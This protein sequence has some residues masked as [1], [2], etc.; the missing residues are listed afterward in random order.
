[1]PRSTGLL[2]DPANH[3]RIWFES[4]GLH[5]IANHNGRIAAI[6]GYMRDHLLQDYQLPADALLD[7]PDGL[8][9]FEWSFEEGPPALSSGAQA[10]FMLAL[11][12]ARPYKG[13]DDLLDALAELRH[14]RIPLPHA[15]L[16]AVTDQPCPTSYQRHLSFSIKSLGLDATLLT[17]FDPAIRTLLA[18]PALRTVVIPS[19]AEPFGRVPLEA[20]AAGA[21]PV[22]AT[23]AGGLAEQVIDGVTGLTASPADPVSLARAIDRALSLTDDERDRMRCAGRY[24][25]RTLFD[26]RRAVR[27]FLGQFAPYI[28]LAESGEST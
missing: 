17:R 7:L 26:S 12:T 16:A 27:R 19:R 1:V 24:L 4:D 25:A 23:T 10:G 13:W 8:T 15:L 14:Q 20:Y 18:H 5:Y 9:A 28:A 2:H 3:A 22:V 21:A 11:G 6:S